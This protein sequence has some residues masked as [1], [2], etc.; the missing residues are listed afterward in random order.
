M[1]RI[2]LETLQV[3]SE[4]ILK[5]VWQMNRNLEIISTDSMEVDQ[6]LMIRGIWLRK[7][8]NNSKM[9]SEEISLIRLEKRK[10]RLMFVK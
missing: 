10:K 2:R 8:N 7:L 6:G 1:Q 4:E 3:I 5:R 9:K